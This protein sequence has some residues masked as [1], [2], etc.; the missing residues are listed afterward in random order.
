V[1]TAPDPQDSLE[2]YL[3]GVFQDYGVDYTL[4]AT[5]ITYANP[6]Q[7]GDVLLAYYRLATAGPAATFVDDETPMGTINGINDTFMLVNAPSPGN[8]LK[9]YLN[10][11]LQNY[12][13]DY[14]LA[15]STITFA[16][17]PQTGDILLC[18]YRF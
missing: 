8:S 13:V 15:G 17:P 10:G 14:T 1:A 6:P 18:N 2:L 12:G 16:A 3:N 7:T 5:A 9:L 11:L 4:A